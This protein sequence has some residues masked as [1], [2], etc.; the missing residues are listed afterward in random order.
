MIRNVYFFNF[1]FSMD[2][3]TC[4]QNLLCHSF[5]FFLF[6]SFFF[7]K[8]ISPFYY[9]DGIVFL[10]FPSSDNYKKNWKK[11]TI[12][13]NVLNYLTLGKEGGPVWCPDNERMGLR[14]SWVDAVFWEATHSVLILYQFNC[15]D[16]ILPSLA[17]DIEIYSYGSVFWRSCRFSSCMM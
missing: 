16:F 13:L 12:L 9:F 7:M 1:L 14:M 11:Y 10:S 4:K 15:S 17:C 3:L 8:F 2:M 6:F 5:L